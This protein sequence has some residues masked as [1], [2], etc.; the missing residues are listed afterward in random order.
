MLTIIVSFA[1]ELFYAVGTNVIAARIERKIPKARLLFFRSKVARYKQILKK[2][3][4]E[5]PFLYK[6][7]RVEMINDFA[8]IEIEQV[9]LSTFHF[10]EH[11]YTKSSVNDKLKDSKRVLFLG[12]AGIGK[13]T[14]QRHVILKLLTD[15]NS[16]ECFYP[17]ENPLPFYVPL[18]AVDDSRRNPIL[19][20]ILNNSNLFTSDRKKSLRQLIKL[21]QRRGIFL[22]IDGY[23]EIQF[24]GGKMNFVQEELN[25][26]M[27]P[28][29][30]S[31]RV[32]VPSDP[33]ESDFYNAVNNCRVWLT[34]RRE[35]YKH[36]PL[37]IDTDS[38]SKK[39]KLFAVALKG[40]YEHRFQLITS[41]FNK[42]PSHAHLLSP[43]YFLK[44]IDN[45]ADSSV[46]ELSYNP[47]FLTIM[48]YVY[49]RKVIELGHFQIESATNYYDLITEFIDL[50]LIDLDSNKALGKTAPD[51]A[52]EIE[53]RNAFVEEKRAFLSYFAVRLFA[54]SKAVF[55]RSY[56]DDSVLTF[57]QEHPDFENAEKISRETIRQENR[58]L[59]FSFQ[60]LMQGVFVLID[61]QSERDYYDFP[62]K[63]FR[64]VLAAQYFKKNGYSFLTENVENENLSELWIVLFQ[65]FQNSQ[66]L[67]EALLSSTSNPSKVDYKGNLLLSCLKEIQEPMNLKDSLKAFLFKNIDDNTWFNL[68]SEVL[69]ECDFTFSENISKRIYDAFLKS[70]EKRSMYALS[71]CCYLLQKYNP[72]LLNQ[73]SMDSIY[74]LLRKN[75]VDISR[76]VLCYPEIARFIKD[77]KTTDEQTR[78]FLKVA[79]LAA[80]VVPTLKHAELLPKAPVENCYLFTKEITQEVHK[81]AVA[82]IGERLSRTQT[83]SLERVLA[84]VRGKV[85]FEDDF[86]DKLPPANIPHLGTYLIQA[87]RNDFAHYSEFVT[88]YEAN[89][90]ASLKVFT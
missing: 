42:Y 25:A 9:S 80:T 50:L 58:N 31:V 30:F 75:D 19:S 71:T 83:A 54:E 17:D 79:E 13:T 20:Y 66:Q 14:F 16:V 51:R 57:F 24:L 46:A 64:E 7:L 86:V 34:S 74:P 26:I 27:R 45:A 87:S 70:I 88:I 22:C 29:Y 69:E 5:M 59:V 62:H 1:L 65:L 18:K 90:K 78:G 47:L 82:A 55:D 10:V 49:A 40:I 84:E 6:D 35:F 21:I 33:K 3:V 73:L 8:N 61:R 43:K 52:A 63:R 44:Q 39:S 12:N 81:L 36:H 67:F 76:L 60:L 2:T 68:P 4:G 89:R 15:R 56:I 32:H 77:A 38:S 11:A 23:D 41:I 37:E 53:I 85:Y 48:C 28:T 72:S